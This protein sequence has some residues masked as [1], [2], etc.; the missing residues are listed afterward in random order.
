[1]TI[2]KRVLTLQL[3]TNGVIAPLLKH[4]EECT[5]SVLFG[6]QA[7]ELVSEIPPDLEIEDGFFKFQIGENDRSITEKKGLYKT[8]LLKKGFEDLVKGI[9]YSLREAYIYVSIIS[10]SSELKT[11]EDFKR[12]FTSIRTQALRMH[13]PNMIEKIEPH[14]A[15][16][17]SYKNQILSINKGRTCLVHRNGLVTEKDIN[18]TINKALKL[19][20]VKYKIFY[21][22]DG[23]EIE[24]MGKG[25]IDLGTG[26]MV[27]I[28]RE[29][30]SISFKQGERITFNYRQFNEFIVTCNHFGV[31]L[32]DCLPKEIR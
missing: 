31:D 30:N 32:V 5:N 1:M 17:W 9:E 28:R 14:L 24:I 3:N 22:K 15:K 7:I 20:W 21:E 6:L 11:D 23:K 18:D 4:L 10:K 2:T 13:I 16:P 12:I 26:T 8:W 19:A 25:V 27:K 29:D